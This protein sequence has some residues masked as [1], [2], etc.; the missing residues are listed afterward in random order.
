M[1]T[2]INDYIFELN[3]H[4]AS[5]GPPE[6]TFNAFGRL[7]KEVPKPNTWYGEN[8]AKN[9]QRTKLSGNGGANFAKVRAAATASG[10]VQF[11]QPI[12]EHFEVMLIDN[13]FLDLTSH[14]D[15]LR[16]G[17]EGKL[18]E[19]EQK[20]TAFGN[21]LSYLIWGDG[22]GAVGKGDGAYSVAGNVITLRNKNSARCFQVGDVL[23]FAAAATYEGTPRGTVSAVRDGTVT[24]TKVNQGAGTITLSGNVTAGISAAVNT[25]YI[26]KD[27]YVGATNPI[28]AGVF[29]WLAR[30]N[31]LAAGTLYGVDCSVYPELMAG[32]RVNLTGN[33]TPW[34]ICSRIMRE[35]A[36]AGAPID[37]IYV[38]S[39]E[40]EALMQEMVSTGIPYRPVTVGV[41]A[42]Q[43]LRIMVTGVEV[44]WGSVKAVIIDDPYLIDHAATDTTDKTYVGLVSSNWQ[45]Q[46]APSGVGW[47]DYSGVGTFLTRETSA[48]N[49]QAEYGAYGNFQCLNNGHQ[50]VACVG[51]SS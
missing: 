12:A 37:R 43:N 7:F 33:E 14:P 40:I 10:G 46:T 17:M 39:S 29:T 2:G 19:M 8:T 1:A 44:G 47:K 51:A 4:W 25:D 22:R 15:A 49:Q 42:P 38:P 24:V 20:V 32:R 45:F 9:P 35:A 41:D 21:Q 27:S 48:Q 36:I 13:L 3:E 5:D 28:S 26:I 16:S 50:I 31:T 11:D 30:T 34:T 23:R 6:E 18:D